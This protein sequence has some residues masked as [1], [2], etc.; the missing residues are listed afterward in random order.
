MFKEIRKGKPNR[1]G[2]DTQSELLYNTLKLSEFLELDTNVLNLL[3]K[4]NKI[5]FDVDTYD[6]PEITP[7]FI[8]EYCKDL[9][10]LGYN[11]FK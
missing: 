9:K 3:V 11:D 1:D 10:V 2:Y 7:I 5:D 4:I 6:S 8:K